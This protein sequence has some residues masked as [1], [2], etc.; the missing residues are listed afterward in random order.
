MIMF[1]S[2]LFFLEFIQPHN[3]WPYIQQNLIHHHNQ[4][5]T[6]NNLPD[7]D[8]PL[9]VTNSPLQSQHHP[10]AAIINHQNL[11]GNSHEDNRMDYRDKNSI[12]LAKPLASRPPPTFLHHAAAGLNHP[13]LH[14]LLAHC[15]N[16]Y[17]GGK[18]H[19]IESFVYL[20]I[21]LFC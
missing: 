6:I 20:I 1:F 5:G 4:F 19:L 13:H 15:R 18:F 12:Q 3:F 7:N 10:H 21:L 14:S 9:L 16:P 11:N 8:N 17:I 2:L